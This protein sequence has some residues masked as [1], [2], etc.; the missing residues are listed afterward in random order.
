MVQ[1]N[2]KEGFGVTYASGRYEEYEGMRSVSYNMGSDVFYVK[3]ED[4]EIQERDAT[5]YFSIVSLENDS[6][7]EF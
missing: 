2:S 7:I 5:V 4:G 1:L 6:F 3:W